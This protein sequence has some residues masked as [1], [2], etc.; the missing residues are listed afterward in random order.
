MVLRFE[1]D[2][3]ERTAAFGVALAGVLKPGDVVLL[4]GELGSGKTTLVRAVA[5]GLG[6]DAGL[7]SSP[8]F[9]TINEYP[10][11]VPLV[12]V[13]AYRLGCADEL[14]ALG[15]DAAMEGGGAGAIVMVE[16]A[17]RIAGA[18][19]CGGQAATIRFTHAGLKARSM[20]LE[21]PDSWKDRDGFSNLERLTR[22]S[23]HGV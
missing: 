12:H 14:E 21:A 23:R 20:E 7:V 4:E 5:S 16:W 11:P 1:S 3:P 17:D 6:I 10:G 2:S 8:T 19:A 15:W 9:V 22:T 13:D 18:P